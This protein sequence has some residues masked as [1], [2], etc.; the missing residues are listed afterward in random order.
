MRIKTHPGEILLE[1]FMKPY[2]LQIEKL[3]IDLKI[4]KK[5][6]NDIIQEKKSITLDFAKK[7]AKQFKT[8]DKFWINLQT[9]YDKSKKSF[10]E[11]EFYNLL[12]HIK[13][14]YFL[15][16]YRQNTI[17]KKL[18]SKDNIFYN[19]VKTKRKYVDII[20]YNNEVLL[21]KNKALIK[22]KEV[23]SVNNKVVTEKEEISDVSC[24]A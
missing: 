8:S 1:E 11:K 6:L 23:I 24:A 2:N 12:K 21:S 20:N 5:E 16:Q 3:A 4:D 13:F 22:K 10:E 7:L 9:N 15:E 18:P 17:N 19:C 14:D